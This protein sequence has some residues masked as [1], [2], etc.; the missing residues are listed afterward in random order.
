MPGPDLTVHHLSFPLT[1]GLG[2]PWVTA[3]MHAG[4]QSVTPLLPEDG[5]LLSGEGEKFGDL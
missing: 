2:E 1:F 5:G 3:R 4:D